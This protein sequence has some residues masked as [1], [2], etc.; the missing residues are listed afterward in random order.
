MA[1]NG[2]RQ[3]LVLSQSV[4]LGEFSGDTVSFWCKVK[5]HYRHDRQCIRALW[6]PLHPNKGSQTSVHWGPEWTTCTAGELGRFSKM[7]VLRPCALAFLIGTWAP[8]FFNPVPRESIL[9]CSQVRAP[10]H[11]WGPCRGPDLIKCT[12]HAQNC[13]IT[14]LHRRK[15]YPHIA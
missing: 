9:M 12:V 5:A 3:C 15:T 6:G 4:Y 7:Q 10:S 2:S 13:M 1:A 8:V 11:P 14:C